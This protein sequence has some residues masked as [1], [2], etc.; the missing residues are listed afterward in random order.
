MTGVTVKEEEYY[1]RYGKLAPMSPDS[2]ANM[3]GN[4][5]GSH[6]K[7]LV[8]RRALEVL[9]GMYSFDPLYLQFM[10]RFSHD[11][12][13]AL[14]ISMDENKFSDTGIHTTFD[15][16]RTVPGYMMNPMSY[17][18][19]NNA[20]YRAELGLKPGYNELQRKIAIE[21]WELVW[22]E[23]KPSPVKI[24]KKSAGGP[25]RNTSDHE[26]KQDF[27]LFLFQ[28]DRFETM[29]DAVDRDDWLTLANDFEMLFMMYIQKRDQV[30]TPGKARQVFDLLFAQTNGEK[31]HSMDADKTVKIEGTVW[32]DFSATRARVI[33][34]GPWVINC[35]LSIVAT[36]TMQSLFDR[37]PQTWHVNTPEQIKA[38]IDGSLIWCGDVKEYDRSM[39]K[40]AIDVA[41]E[42]MAQFWDH[43][44][45]KASLNL[46][47]SP[48]YSRPLELDG[49][50]GQMFGDPRL[51]GHQ[52]ICGNRSG[53]AMTSL[54]AKVN[55]VIETL[56][57][58][59]IMGMSV[60]GNCKSFL[61]NREA[62]GVVNNG[63]DEI[64]HTKS[65]AL[66]AKFKEVR[67]NPEHCVYIVEAEDGQVYSG[68][69]LR[70]EK[71]GDKIYHPT[72][73]LATTFEKIYCP[74]RPVGGMFRPYWYIGVTERINARDLH[75]SG[76]TAW[77]IH[78]KLFTDMLAPRFGTL[79]GMLAD[80]VMHAPIR[81]YDLTTADR[82]VLE[83]PERIHYKYKDG[84]ISEQVLALTTL[85]LPF[86][87]FE[88]IVSRSYSG[89][90]H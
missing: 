76:A 86:N 50:R 42:T 29:L 47:Y 43:R 10:Q 60:V 53:H 85:N 44:I 80:A 18:M 49:K 41:H 67:A 87:T 33:H 12:N 75:P 24:T 84:E 64:T 65:D 11:L 90:V 15:R 39:P 51:L 58:F 31:G 19:Q 21:V 77:E 48:Y 5:V 61:L 13:D 46:Y 71:F 3:F 89:H 63:D 35:F 25:R 83:R 20:S 81:F 74:E 52:V 78:D 68:M 72:P 57:I 55:K 17:T 88:H 45:A 8:S 2:L 66:M 7:P 30:D 37:F 23:Y 22:S 34:A 40:E 59:Q 56:Y 69:V 27:A 26:W 9:P 32:D 82:D 73:R 54:M 28:S 6:N 79:Y 16:L 38:V 70:V 1:S 62:C 14:P 4:G 36:G